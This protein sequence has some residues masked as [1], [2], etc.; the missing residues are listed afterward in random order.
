VALRRW[1]KVRALLAGAAVSPE[2]TSLRMQACRGILSAYWRVGGAHVD[3]D[4]V[5]AEGKALAEQAGDLQSLA[6]LFD[7]YGNA[8]GAAG[9]LRAYHELASEALRIAERTGD[10]LIQAVIASDAHPFCWTGR[11][12]ETV[13][14]TE[15]AIALG[16]GGLSRGRDMLGVGAYLLGLMFRGAALVEMGRLGDAATD[17]DRASQYAGETTFIWSQ[18]YHV[19]RAYR[20]WDASEALMHARRALERA[21]GLRATFQILAQTALGL[22]LLTS[23]E[24][25][26]AE[27]AERR[28]LALARE[29]D[30]TFGLTAWVL[31]FLADAK[32]GQGDP[33]AALE[34]AD[35]ALADARR[36]GGRLFEMDALLT[37][38]ELSSAP[39]ARAAAPRWSVPSRRPPH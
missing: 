38:R 4:S 8:K 18:A 2:T 29:S 37:A 6:I 20:A 15:K 25:S 7:V 32:L 33:N 36:S 14:L 26:A 39:R 17:L 3:V 21:A 27:E 23:R 35:E 13:R 12:Q 28:A 19:V 30:L 22:A 9:D 24:W 31:C 10:S 16:P 1:S 11:L 5:F 34:L